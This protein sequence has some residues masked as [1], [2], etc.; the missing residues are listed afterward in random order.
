MARSSSGSDQDGPVAPLTA[1]VAPSLLREMNQRLLLDRL[2][3]AGPATRPQLARTAGLSQPTVIAAL[4]DLERAGLV[5]AGAGG[6]RRLGR[7]AKL[8]AANPT[9][10]SVAGID[11]GR[12]WLH[13]RVADLLGDT[14]SEL[15]VRNTA[16]SAAALVE[17]TARSLEEAAEKA[18]LS[19]G[20]VTHTAIGSPGVLDPRRGGVRYAANLPGWHQAG[21]AQALADR[22]GPAISVDNDANLA[23][24]AELTYGAARGLKDV[25]YLTVG[26]GV[27]VGLVLNGRVYRG[28]TGAAGEVGYLPIGERSST[29]RAGRAARG[30]LEEAVAADAVVRYA[31]QAGLTGRITAER[32]FELAHHG[33]PR[34]LEAIAEEGRQ[35]ALAVASI[36]ALLDPELIVLGGR[37]G[38]NLDLLEPAITA[39]LRE[40]TP[41]RP[42]LVAGELGEDAVVR[43]AIARGTILARETVFTDRGA[44]SG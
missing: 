30:M 39:A 29:A 13:L 42:T 9:A 5:T 11:I 31:R 6:G 17:L 14:L 40:V 27:G 20:S 22:I 38:Q 32:V 4:D 2:F 3:T 36:A 8:Y 25:A 16:K 43:G 21:L 26:S 34:A 24:L 23:A 18:G 19:A 33:E 37:V 7:P 10:G 28:F 12:G 44:A 15:S 41:M 35:L 1:G